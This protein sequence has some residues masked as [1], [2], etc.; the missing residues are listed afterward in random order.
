[1]NRILA[2]AKDGVRI[3]GVDHVT[4]SELAE[5]C[6]CTRQTIYHH[7]GGLDGLL[8]N[9][10]LYDCSEIDYDG[11]DPLGWK[12]ETFRLLCSLKK[13]QWLPTDLY[14]HRRGFLYDTL[15]EHIKERVIPCILR[16]HKR[17]GDDVSISEISDLMA[18][19]FA[20]SIMHWTSEN[21]P[22]GPEDMMRRLDLICGTHM[23]LAVDTFLREVS[24]MEK[25]RR[26]FKQSYNIRLD[27]PKRRGLVLSGIFFPSSR[28]DPSDRPHLP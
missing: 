13:N 26:N 16:S 24:D 7:F 20:G 19:F 22:M 25:V 23:H 28:P 6:Q 27:V 4:V 11:L 3:K 17:A 21:L 2:S 9:I 1:M 10:L 18:T 14:A 15:R 12:Q 5:I 8:K